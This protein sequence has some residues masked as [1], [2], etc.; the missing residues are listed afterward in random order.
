MSIKKGR[1]RSSGLLAT[2]V[3]FPPGTVISF[4][5]STAPEGWM[6]CDGSAI[7]RTDYAGLF[8]AIGTLWGIGDGLN[9]FN[10]PDLEGR[11]LRG[12]DNG[13]TVDP[14]A[15]TRVPLGSGVANG[16]GSLQDDAIRNIT[17]SIDG[18]LDVG[19]F[20]RTNSGA[21]TWTGA[22]DRFTTSATSNTNA[23]L[24][25]NFSAA[26]SVTTAADNRPSNCSVNYII[27]L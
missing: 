3:Q 6:I 16:V 7:S 25:M 20:N 23:A 21:F 1:L 10:L 11:F 8:A 14:D 19:V 2:P 9:T 12:A 4:A 5:G 27:K 22:T 24:G 15:G 18:F 13:A 26:N 17:G